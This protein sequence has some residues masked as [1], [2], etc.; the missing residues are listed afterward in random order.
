MLCLYTLHTHFERQF[1]LVVFID[2]ASRY[3]VPFL[4][5]IQY[6]S[7]WLD[8]ARYVFNNGIGHLYF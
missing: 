2:V 4:N 6:R 1:L 5:G 3:S 8:G 7:I